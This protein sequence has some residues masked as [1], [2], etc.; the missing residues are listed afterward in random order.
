[1]V[2]AR[3]G[4]RIRLVDIV[5][6]DARRKTGIGTLLIGELIEESETSGKPIR[7][8]VTRTNAAERLYQRMGF[9]AASDDGVMEEMERVPRVRRGGG[10]V[11]G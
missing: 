9:V 7:L 1:M 5:I 3:E 2:V 11:D 6:G 10:F 4:D 8:S